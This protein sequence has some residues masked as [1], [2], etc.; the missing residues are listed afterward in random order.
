MK[1]K[2]QGP[3]SKVAL[4]ALA[5][6][7]FLTH[8][9]IA[10][11]VLVEAENFATNGGWKV[12][13]QFAEQMGSPFLIAHGMGVPVSNAAT[14]VAFP[15]TGDYAV[16]ARTRNW[17]PAFS[18]AAAPGRFKVAVSGADL[19]PVFG[20]EGAAWHWQSG[21][22]VTVSG[23]AAAVEL[24]DLTGFDGRCDA[25]AFIK[26]SS[27]PPP[28][29]GPALAAWRKAALDESDAPP[30][31]MDFDC[32][33][34]GGGMAGCCAAIAA[35]RSG[36]AVVLVQ[37][38]P[39]LGGNSSQEIRVATRGEKRHPI[40]EEIDSTDLGNRDDRAV[41]RDIEREMIVTAETNITLFMPWRAYAASTNAAGRVAHVDIRHTR[42]G[43]RTRLTGM[44]FVDCT[45]DGWVG[46]WAG[47]DYRMGREASAEF[48]ESLAP[49]A[50]DAKTLGSSLMWSSRDTG[51]P[52]SFPAVPWAMNV[53]G[54][55][56]ATYGDWNWEYGMSLDTI[57]DAE[58]IR[59]HLLRAIYG[60]FANAK[61][62]PANINLALAWVPHVAG[63]R[64]SRRL[65]GDHILT[66]SDLVQGVYFED[67]VATTDW[68][69][70][71]HY[72]TA[73]SYLS[74]YRK[75]SIKK[76]YFP[77]RCL[78]SRNVPNLMM[79]GRC[80]STSHV[81]IGSPRVQNTTAQ[82]GV[83]VGYAA[84]ICKDYGI[85]PRDIYRNA[86]R[87]VE[88]QA[89]I[90]GAW[91][92]RP[93][94]AG[95]TLDNASAAPAVTIVGDW[96][97]SDYTAGYYG[98]NYLHDGN[99]GRG[100]KRVAFTPALSNPGFYA[101]SLRWADGANRASNT[102][103]WV[104]SSPLSAS[105]AA[106]EDLYIR[107]AQP[108]ASFTTGEVLVGRFAANDYTRGLLRF[109]LSSIP[110]AAVIVSAELD[111]EIGS[112]DADT[113]PGFVG[114]DGLK[115]YRVTSP[116][117]PADAT[118]NRRAAETNW[119]AAGGDFDA[120]ALSTIPT[121]TDPNLAEAGDVFVFPRTEAL[122][123]AAANARRQGATLDLMIRTPT[124]ES[125]YPARKLYRF[126]N[127]SLEVGY[128][129]PQL[130]ATYSVD[131]RTRGGQWVTLGSHEL[132]PGGLT[133][134]VGNDGA[135]GFVIAD[136]VQFSSA[137]STND[138]DGDGLVDAWERYY[139][140]SE[141][142]ATPD[143]D[144]DDD[145]RSNHAEFMTGT[146]PTDP[147][148][149]FDMRMKLETAPGDFLIN[150]SSVAGRTYA[151]ETSDDLASFTPLVQGIRATPPQNSYVVPASAARR[152]YRVL[153]EP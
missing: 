62:N 107:N 97:S 95:I 78:Y 73:V 9:A 99:A 2:V 27:S 56:A 153:L 1:P 146:D 96:T 82:M 102:P 60:N 110:A 120:A 38:R 134:I 111:L 74:T 48:G 15:E 123:A 47:A 63:K 35:A 138:Y 31:S 133:V 52:V 53:A 88:L 3:K 57:N 14:T 115:V 131:Q 91:P 126:G 144:A 100:N 77:F 135:S 39:V 84:A 49:A 70:D 69:I 79:A 32:V 58:A 36:V 12:D 19:A 117:T 113:A 80:F 23:A 41:G 140:L 148:S 26:G 24:K 22:T 6:G 150:W 20:A 92:T 124:L 118:W 16:W 86:D 90:A 10:A 137:S 40:V 147:H 5:A 71:L 145:G 114:A 87:T 7:G 28:D 44:I 43:E 103:V 129:A 76:C 109:D 139:F 55:R 119:A 89:R 94:P 149:R 21:G 34:V 18:N 30:S 65:L 13:T 42:T 67:A 130:P 105:N 112:L 101:I 33:I 104:L 85:E 136:A 46:Y 116:F 4:V 143:A 151:I 51:T 61:T 37:D 121:P 50:P 122:T 68:G 45:G 29:G 59:D 125:S 72:E 11:T 128:F 141:T 8:A 64:E 54:T 142:G 106:S 83:A 75:T 66:Q 81:A 152:Y 127:A 132:P 108:D 25:V 98:T 93:P 17:V